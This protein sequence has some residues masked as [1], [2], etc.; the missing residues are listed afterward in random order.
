MRS[1]FTGLPALVQHKN[2]FRVSR[3]VTLVEVLVGVFLMLLVFS[4]FFGAYAASADLVRSA[5]AR[6]GAITLAASSVES[7]RKLP[8]AD[9]GTVGGTP[10]GELLPSE[11]KSLNGIAY[12]LRTV[13]IYTDDP[14]NGTGNDYKSVKVE[15]LWN[16]R[17][18][19][20]NLS[21]VTYVAP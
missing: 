20:Q 2:L 10:S 14:A 4:G 11:F 16:F 9:V 8:Y 6:M 18:A 21:L 3:G 17:G 5:S 13:V 19:S 12:T 7:I 1:A 15:A